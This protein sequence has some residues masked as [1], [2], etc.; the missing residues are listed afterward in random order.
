MALTVVQQNILSQIQK[1]AEQLGSIQSS[2][3]KLSA[4]WTNEFQTPPTTDDL[5]ALPEFAHVT[6][7]EL[8][9]AATALVA[10]SNVLGTYATSASNINKLAKIAHA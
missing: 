2:M 7:A 8:V 9:D 10:I 6:Q 3:V 5:K 1:I 4:M